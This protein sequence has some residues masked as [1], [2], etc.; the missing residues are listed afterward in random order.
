VLTEQIQFSVQLLSF[1]LQ[2][3]PTTWTCN[4]KSSVSNTDKNEKTNQTD[5]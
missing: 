3:L 5:K 4:W 1:I 2:T